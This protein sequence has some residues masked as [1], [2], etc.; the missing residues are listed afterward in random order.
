MELRNH[1]LISSYGGLP[2]W[3]PAWSW[4]GGKPD[5]HPK[6]EV[7]ALRRVRLAMIPPRCFLIIER[8]GAEYEGCLT[9]DDRDFCFHI[10]RLLEE[11]IGDRIEQIGALILS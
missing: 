10:Y 8:D 3:P 4:T 6:G 11:H 2:Q 5:T 9:F 7:G 1:P